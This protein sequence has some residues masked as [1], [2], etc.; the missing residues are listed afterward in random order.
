V[1]NRGIDSWAAESH[2]PRQAHHQVGLVAAIDRQPLRIP[3]VGDTQPPTAA[4]AGQHSRQQRLAAPAGLYAS[5]ATVIVKRQLLLVALVLVPADVAFVMILDH[6]LPGTNRLA[7]SV[8]APRSPFDDRGTPLAFPVHVNASVK[9]VLQSGDDVAVADWHPGEVGH[10]ACVGGPWEVD[11]VSRHRQQHLT[12]AA[13]LAEASEDQLDHFL[14]ADVR[15]EAKARFAMPNVAERNRQAQLA[16]A[17]LR[18]H[19][20]EHPSPQDAELELA[21]AALHAQEQ[22]IVRATGIVH[23]VE[24]NHP[25]FDQPAQFKQ[26]MPV[27]AISS[28]PGCVEAQHGADLARTQP[29]NQAI[30]ARACNCAAG[31]PAE[32]VVNDLNIDKAAL[33]RDLHE[34][35]LPALAFQVGHDLGLR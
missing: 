34:I 13:Q 10:A 30:E 17:R 15:I 16:P 11:L 1:R 5:P 26:M 25:R 21:D 31:R 19:G 27:A 3:G 14:E 23:P 18:S 9:R 4:A 32:I 6:H 8:A 33:A 35:I 7:M 29:G 24:I 12:R 20:I 28:E 2:A 22:A